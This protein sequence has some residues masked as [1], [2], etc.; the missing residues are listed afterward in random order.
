MKLNISFILIITAGLLKITEITSADLPTFFQGDPIA[1]EK[2]F[3]DM[4]NSVSNVGTTDPSQILNLGPVETTVK[5]FLYTQSNTANP[6]TL[7]VG[8]KDNLNNSPFDSASKTKII[9]HGWTDSSLNPFA[10]CISNSYLKKE[11]Y[12][13][14]IVDWSLISMNEYTTAV[15]L[16]RL[17]GEY[18]GKMVKFLNTEG[19]Q[20]LSDIHAMGS[21]LGAHVA[22]FAGSYVSGGMGRI[23]GLDPAG[24]LFEFPYLKDPADRLD[25]TDAVFV[26]IIHTCSG[27]AGFTRAIGHVDFY[28]NNGTAPQPGCPL[29]VTV[30]CSHAWALVLMLNSI[31]YPEDFESVKCDSWENYEKGGCSGNSITK[32]GEYVDRDARGKFYLKTSS[33]LDLC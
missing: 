12:N 3:S 2:K 1:I 21:S 6:Y 9:I 32:M 15:K 5:F 29:I 19:G 28:P 14:I 7:K 11:N 22:G 8:D 25:E 20:S 27:I 23:T 33:S 13:V 10:H 26:D 30:T 16:A 31:K 4:T 24:P 18:I 17:V